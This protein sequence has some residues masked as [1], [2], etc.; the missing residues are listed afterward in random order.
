MGSI[1]QVQPR[2]G[3]A[4]AMGRGCQLSQEVPMAPGGCSP[5]PVGPGVPCCPLMSPA[6]PQG[7]HGS[8]PSR[9][10]PSAT[11]QH[12]EPQP[13][14]GVTCLSPRWRLKRVPL[15]KAGG[16][17]GGSSGCRQGVP[18]GPPSVPS[19]GTVWVMTSRMADDI[20]PQQGGDNASPRCLPGSGGDGVPRDIPSST[21]MS[22]SQGPP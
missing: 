1:V 7:G 10:V 15:P 3:G 13:A 21:M 11:L 5:I 20:T 12:A 9:G 16:P 18:P 14:Q 8:P 17:W 6:V 4:G 2:W 19:D 22:P